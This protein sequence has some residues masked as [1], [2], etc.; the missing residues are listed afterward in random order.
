MIFRGDKFQGV[1]MVVFIIFHD[2]KIFEG[3]GGQDGT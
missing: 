2:R 1:W 3:F